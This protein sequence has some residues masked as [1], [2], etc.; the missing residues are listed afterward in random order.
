MAYLEAFRELGDV[1]MELTL[2]VRP[3]PMSLGRFFGA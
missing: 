3:K 1:D 2:V